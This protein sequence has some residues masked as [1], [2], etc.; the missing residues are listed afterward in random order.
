M[1]FIWSCFAVTNQIIDLL[2]IKDYR[3]FGVCIHNKILLN[4]SECDIIVSV[5]YT[6]SV[7]DMVTEDVGTCR[8]DRNTS[9]GCIYSSG[10]NDMV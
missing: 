10:L 9:V 8:W 5:T 7:S 3:P 6:S 1:S 2:K 4:H